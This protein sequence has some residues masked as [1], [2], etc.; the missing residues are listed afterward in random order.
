M[1]VPSETLITEEKARKYFCDLVLGIEY[2][3]YI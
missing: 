2:C 3:K 1:E